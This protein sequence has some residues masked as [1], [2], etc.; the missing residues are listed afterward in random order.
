MCRYGVELVP[1]PVLQA[2][3]GKPRPDLNFSQSPKTIGDA[4]MSDFETINHLIELRA[5]DQKRHFLTRGL[6]AK[7]DTPTPVIVMVIVASLLSFGH[8][9]AWSQYLPPQTLQSQAIFHPLPTQDYAP[10]SMIR[11][12]VIGKQGVFFRSNDGRPSRTPRRGHL[13]CISDGNESDF[14]QL[15]R[16]SS[17]N[18]DTVIHKQRIHMYRSSTNG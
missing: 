13:P 16:R 14:L 8:S 4:R 1:C 18:P 9:H 5:R 17:A 2:Q 7:T 6:K 10:C 3:Q 15:T 12:L 11:R